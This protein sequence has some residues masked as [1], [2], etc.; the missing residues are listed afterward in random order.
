MA[1]RND[2]EERLYRKALRRYREDLGHCQQY[3]DTD[4]QVQQA[5]WYFDAWRW[6]ENVAHQYRV[7]T[8]RVAALLAV[9]SP[10]LSYDRNKAVVREVLDRRSRLGIPAGVSLDG[11]GIT[12]DRQRVVLNIL[13]GYPVPS[14][15]RKVWS[16]YHNIMGNED[17][18]TIDRHMIYPFTKDR[19]SKAA[20]ITG[21]QYNALERAIITLA[22][23]HNMVPYQL[24]AL[25][26]AWYRRDSGWAKRDHL[27]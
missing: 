10:Q 3:W 23:D 22:K 25:L 1:K 16:F 7:D 21:W 12:R 5:T 15:G 6:C 11:I 13:V 2:K 9:T 18:V 19:T 8:E 27:N 26:W 24:Q 14:T 17:Y 20:R 4:T